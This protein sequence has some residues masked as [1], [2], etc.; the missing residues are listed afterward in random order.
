MST[1]G[2]RFVSAIKGAVSPFREAFVSRS[3]AFMIPLGFAS[4]LPR[5]LTAS[6][7]AAWMTNEGVDLTTIGIFA[8]VG[9]SYRLKF[10][11][12][13]LLDRYSVPWLSRRRGWMITTQL[14]LVAA[15]ILMGLLTPSS[16][17]A[18][19]AAAAVAVAFLSSSQDIVIDAYRTDVLEQKQR[20]SGAAV[21][22]AMYRAAMIVAGAGALIVSEF[23]PW[24]QVY[25]LLAGLM[26]IGIL[27][28]LLSPVPEQ[29][30]APPRSLFKAVWLPLVDYFSRPHAILLLIIV[31]TYKVGDEVASQMVTPFIL[32]ELGFSNA[33]YGVVAKG[34]GL[35]A[36]I[37]G[38][39]VGGGLVVK[40]GLRASLLSFGVL[41]AVANVLYSLLAVTGR[42]YTLFVVTIGVDNVF[43]G[44]GTA[45]FVA[46][47]MSQCS[48]R[49]SAF[50]FALL[51]SAMGVVGLLLSGSSGWIATTAGWPIF[52]MITVIAAI[53]ALVLLYVLPKE[54]IDE[55]RQ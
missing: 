35:V 38:S 47:L 16:M 37:V 49:F 13:P 9:F 6:T 7:L 5:L 54:V 28:T 15:I 3:V 36:T 29:R 24:S 34:F 48:E 50:Q 10:L 26:M 27:G 45:A 46:F 30:G 32:R 14:G 53:P 39:L 44:L 41:Q 51:S 20:A 55:D 23:L 52:F 18:A 31:M 12:A 43:N 40:F 22:V 25:F 8:W 17:P 42:N 4:G 33:E 11:W 21:F 19:M 2:Q 1:A